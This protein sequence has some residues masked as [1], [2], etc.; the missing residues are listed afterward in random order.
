MSLTADFNSFATE[1]FIGRIASSKMTR[2]QIANHLDMSV[3]TL[4]VKL[5]HPGKFTITEYNQLCDLLS[6]NPL[7]QLYHE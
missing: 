6:I 1:A 4:R 7:I 2:Q 5:R 3:E